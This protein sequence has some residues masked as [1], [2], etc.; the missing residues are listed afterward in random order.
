MEQDNRRNLIQTLLSVP[1]GDLDQI[2]RVHG[3]VSVADPYF[4]MHVIP[5]L[6]ANSE[7][8]DHISSAVVVGSTSDWQEHRESA[9][10]VLNRLGVM[11]VSKIAREVIKRHGRLPRSFQSEVVAYLRKLHNNKNFDVLLLQ[12]RKFIKFLYQVSHA[13][14]T[15][16]IQRCLFDNNPPEHTGFWAV[17]QAAKLTDTYEK[18]SLLVEYK[19]PYLVMT[20]LLGNNPVS[21]AA[22]VHAMTP[23]EISNNL[24]S[25][26][27]RGVKDNPELWAIIEQKLQR[28]AKQGKLSV[29]RATETKKHVSEQTQ[30]VIDN[31]RNQ[32][33]QQ[34]NIQKDTALFVDISSSMHIAINLAKRL[35]PMVGPA[36]TAK[37]YQVAFNTAVYPI[38]VQGTG[39]EDYERAYRMLSPGGGTSFGAP[40]DYLTVNNLQV[41]QFLYLTDQ[42]ETYLPVFSSSYRAYTKKFNIQPRVVVVHL[43]GGRDQDIE[44]QCRQLGVDCET[45]T[46]NGDYYSLT[47]VLRLLA[48]SSL[49]QEILETPILPRLVRKGS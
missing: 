1:H 18:A 46:W 29:G 6:Y 47:Q 10:G 5:W 36:M 42:D 23:Q 44:N 31:A 19:V 43:G 25:L 35:G 7:V 15:E 3:Q 45:W 32:A 26:E 17:K 40:I 9:L 12:N 30:Q 39:V 33:L 24:K 27:K 28:G 2:V 13:P 21:T 8:R 34:Y 11:Q 37:L 4:Y 20:S 48:K 14:R 49:V 41:G 22:L 16:M 38:A